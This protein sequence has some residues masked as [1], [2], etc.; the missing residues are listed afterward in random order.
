MQDSSPKAVTAA[1]IIV[2][3]EILSGRTQDTNLKH[4][5]ERLGAIGI[6]LV[7]ARVIPDK[8]DVI[9]DTVRAL[10]AR[11]DYLFTTGGIGP[12]H[13][14]I[15]ADCVAAA[16]G[17]AID[18][19]PEARARLEAHY[20]TSEHELN[21]A[22]LRMAR[23][24]DGASLI[25]NPVSVAPGFRLENV[26]VMAGVPRIMAA[27]L[28]GVLPTLKGGARVESVTIRCDLP[29]GTAA[30]GL[31]HVAAD[32]PAVDIGSY[33][34]YG[35]GGFRLSIVVRGVD[36]AAVEDAARAVEK[37][38]QDLGAAAERFDP[39]AG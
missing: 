33:P 25:D 13:D 27:M 30:E 34:K 8:A 12:T 20:A 32:H 24:P 39:A 3:N 36:S 19:H 26:F 22:R 21:E 38:V 7:E 14:D 5:A 18:I 37:L 11:V 23:I 28:D 1:L 10:S 6:S 2:G 16:F 9:T 31:R 4:L 35:S 15:T 29:E 17:R